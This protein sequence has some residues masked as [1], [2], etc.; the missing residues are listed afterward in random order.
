M[1]EPK[2][3]GF[4]PTEQIK[5]AEKVNF[6]NQKPFDG[7]TKQVSGIYEID[8]AHVRVLIARL[9]FW[10]NTMPSPRGASQS[11][12]DAILGMEDGVLGNLLASPQAGGSRYE[13][14]I[15]GRSVKELVRRL[16]DSSGWM[17]YVS[18]KFDQGTYR[19]NGDYAPRTNVPTLPISYMSWAK[20]QAK[21]R[22]RLTRQGRIT[23]IEEVLPQDLGGETTAEAVARFAPPNGQRAWRRR[24]RPPR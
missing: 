22:E 13:P 10:S 15:V 6:F 2:S 21:L 19:P 16:H 20:E 24:T 12:E 1:T 18:S 4:N 14:E 17:V 3:E 7:V 11:R 5:L 8:T 23:G 9:C